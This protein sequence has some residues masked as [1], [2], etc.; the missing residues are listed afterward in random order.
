MPYNH[1]LALVKVAP[2]APRN[3]LLQFLMTTTL[4]TDLHF[5]IKVD[6]VIDLTMM[7]GPLVIVIGK[8]IRRKKN[9]DS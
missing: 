4:Q 5:L 2:C 6:N 9:Q 1:G 3:E 8:S 7:L